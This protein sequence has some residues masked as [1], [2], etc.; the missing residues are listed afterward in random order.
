MPIG[1]IWRAAAACVLTLALLDHARVGVRRSSIV[2]SEPIRSE[3]N[4]EPLAI[5]VNHSNPVTNLSIEELRAVFLGERN[6]W[7]NG[8]RIT[9]VLRDPGDPER[10]AILHDVCG[11]NENQFKTHL[12]HGLF[13]GEILVSPKTLSTPAGVRRFIV[14]VPGAIGPL[15]V[16]Q[17]DDTVSVI[18]IDNRLPTDKAYELHVYSS[19]DK[20]E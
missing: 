15:R 18:R 14:N 17:V 16:S 7:P 9:V 12:L 8:R 4:S 6:Y 19:G 20:S 5:V 11:M 10:D 1:S 3:R 2:A 13:T